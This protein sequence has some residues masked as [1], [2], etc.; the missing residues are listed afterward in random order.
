MRVGSVEGRA[1]SVDGQ[2]VIAREIDGEKIRR[3]G[4]R[5][6]G[7]QA[8]D[9]IRPVA[10]RCL[11]REIDLLDVGGKLSSGGNIQTGVPAEDAQ[12]PQI[13][14]VTGSAWPG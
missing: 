10:P 6:A 1:L 5:R 12:L 7:R 2:R 8:D 4:Q 9:V 11:R 14:G 13:A 3:L